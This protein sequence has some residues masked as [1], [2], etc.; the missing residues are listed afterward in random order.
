MK[1]L[2]VVFL[3]GVEVSLSWLVRAPCLGGLGVLLSEALR[4]GA[5]SD[6]QCGRE[7][8]PEEDDGG[9]LGQDDS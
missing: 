1:S 9:E 4:E 2:S 6:D 3:S 5:R 7:E 8:D